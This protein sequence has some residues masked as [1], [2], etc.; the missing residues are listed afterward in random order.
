MQNASRRT[1]LA[2]AAWLAFAAGLAA[3]GPA[4]AFGA[5]AAAVIQPAPA[6]VPAC[7]AAVDPTPSGVLGRPVASF[8]AP[9]HQ[10]V[11]SSVHLQGLRARVKYAGGLI[12]QPPA[13]TGFDQF[14]SAVVVDNPDPATPLT[15][16]IE[17]FDEAGNPRGTSFPPAIA[18]EGYYN[19]AALPLSSH[20][21][22]NG[23]G[24]ARITTLSGNGVVGAVLIQTPCIS[25]PISIC[26][27]DLP[28]SQN[29]QRVG[30]SEAQQLQIRQA[31]KTELW[32]GPLPLTAA[33]AIDFFNSEAPFLWVVN[34]NGVPNT[35]HVDLVVFDRVAGTSTTQPWR[36][37]TL[38]PNGT[39]L[40]K[41]GPHLPPGPGLWDY[42][43]GQLPMI[44]TSDYDYLVHVVSDSGL[45]IL[46]DGVM[47]DFYG[48]DHSTNPP[49][50]VPGKRFRFSSQMLANTPSWR[51][52]N[53]DFSYEPNGIVQTL[54]GLFNVGTTNAGPVHIEYFDRNGLLISAG[55]IAS[56]PP[57]QSARIVPGAFGYPTTATGYGWVRISACNPDARLVGWT[58]RE[59][60]ETPATEP[61][62][63]K[64]PGEALDGINGQEPGQGF[65]VTAGGQ[66]WLRK[67][68]PLSKVD[69]SFYWPA[70]TTF[71]N[72]EVTNVG[73]YWY[74]FFRNSGAA[75]TNSA[76]QP[77]AGVPWAVTSTSLDDPQASCIAN[78]SS[79]VDLTT[80][81]VRGIQVLGDPF[82]EYAIPGFDL[83]ENEQ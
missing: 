1:G 53:P 36:T 37:I 3:L 7:I 5:D 80:G 11:H 58:V 45:P 46:G 60:L 69:V 71:A 34:P 40:E 32:W 17:Y 59:I 27:Q 83:P 22:V 10:W 51:L 28:L 74:R 14:T 79:R 24:S 67:V 19:E 57:N 2:A 54:M 52:F 63:H 62:Y 75:C 65:A 12:Y 68:G 39:L 15:V 30:A 33:S 49:T 82:D 72:T 16:K 47:T 6:P 70:F 8:P 29:G 48:D 31:D 20:A 18:P 73:P 21:G 55:S 4:P 81:P 42:F 25:Q 77:Y 78:V 26:D 38:N 13:A 35:I 23:V 44:G 41:S 9:D 66:S 50:Q 64:A 76:G 61:H 43:I 56:L